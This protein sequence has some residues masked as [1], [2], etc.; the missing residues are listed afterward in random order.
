M[1]VCFLVYQGKDDVNCLLSGMCNVI[2]R[3]HMLHNVPLDEFIDTSARA[4]EENKGLVGT[5]RVGDLIECPSS[6][7]NSNDCIAGTYDKCISY[8]TKIRWKRNIDIFIRFIL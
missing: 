3:F 4:L 5:H 2:G 6:A 1:F 8:M 7:S